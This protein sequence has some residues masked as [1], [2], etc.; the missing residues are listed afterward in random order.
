MLTPAWQRTC[1]RPQDL[2]LGRE[3][4]AAAP[5]PPDAPPLH[6]DAPP[7]HPHAPPQGA[8]QTQ[9]S[10]GQRAAVRRHTLHLA[11]EREEPHRP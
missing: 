4:T 9:L 1:P 7:L 5:P 3:I 8:L 6:P 11:A 2:L 10:E